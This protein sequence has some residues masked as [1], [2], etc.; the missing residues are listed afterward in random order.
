[1]KLRLTATVVALFLVSASAT[2]A[3][4]VSKTFQFDLSDALP[5]F[6][7]FGSVQIETYNG[8]G[9]SGGGLAAG[10]V[11]MTF[12]PNALAIYGATDSGFGFQQV[13]FNSTLAINNAQISVPTGW[14]LR[15][16]RFMGGFGK[17]KWQAYGNPGDLTGPL[18]ITISDLGAD[19]ILDHFLL[20][21][22][23][24]TG[25]S[26]LLGSV[27]FAGRIG[28]FDLNNDFFDMTSHV[29]G[30]SAAPTP[31]PFPGEELPPVE[32]PGEQGETPNP[33][34]E[35]TTL[36]LGLCGMGGLVAYRRWR[37]L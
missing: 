19:A 17:F 33:T 4:Y 34:P 30:V 29:A 22:T 27:Y 28:G 10:Q 12:T 32:S 21:S 9:A 14:N 3:D 25:E 2:R 36:F 23:S 16:D 37:A 35:P 7:S 5:A 13:G 24:S 8:V 15:N 26:P 6:E 11:R 1:M 18:S 20:G 31:P